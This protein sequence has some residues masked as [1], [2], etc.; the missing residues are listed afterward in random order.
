[1]SQNLGGI[2]FLLSNSY[3]QEKEEMKN[4]LIKENNFYS[5][6]NKKRKRN[7]SNKNIIVNKCPSCA[8]SKLSKLYKHVH[9][10]HE[11]NRQQEKSVN[12]IHANKMKININPQ[13]MNKNIVNNTLNNNKNSWNH[14][15]YPNF[16]S[17]N[18]LNEV[19]NNFLRNNCTFSKHED[20]QN[21]LSKGINQNN[22]ISERIYSKNQANIKADEINIYNRFNK[23]N[24]INDNIRNMNKIHEKNNKELKPKKELKLILKIEKSIA[25]NI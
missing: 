2:K 1:M 11:K 21:P 6:I 20:I 18:N 15:F 24:N 19:Q 17:N 3:H 16:N 4:E 12:D 22:N 13:N 10:I 25:P 8:S 14:N 7:I 9:H 5:L 23:T